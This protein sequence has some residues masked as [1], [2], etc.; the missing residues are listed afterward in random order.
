M[1]KIFPIGFALS[2]LAGWLLGAPWLS[3]A[4]GA[5][6]IPLAE[7]LLRPRKNSAGGQS[8]G[9][10][11][12]WGRTMPRIVLALVVA[13]TLWFGFQA[14]TFSWHTTLWLALSCGYVGGG[15]GIV[16][17]HELDH[18]RAWLDG[19]L[20]RLH[21]LMVGFGHYAL[22]HNRG[23]HRGVA[24]HAD[25]ATARRHES[26]W[27]FLPRY[28]RGVLR[29][30][31]ALSRKM[32]GP[33]NEAL[34]LLAATLMLFAAAFIVAGAPGLVFFLMQAAIA[35]LLVGAVDY[36][37]HWGLVRQTL[38]GKTERL[39]ERHI[40]DAPSVVSEVM[41]FN[42]PR[43]AAH[44]LKPWLQCDALTRSDTAPQMPTGYAGMVILAWIPQLYKKI[45]TPRLP[46]D[47]LTINPP[48]MANP[49]ESKPV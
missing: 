45:M 5:V 44:H 30:S 11:L 17:A 20:C 7:W 47:T 4:I 13:Q 48:L 14:D 27:Q 31:I 6:L 40:W 19:A 42:L 43:H 10:R 33:F 39:T 36:L 15:T 34:A 25:P 49:V 2:P 37:E 22:E 1:H 28:Y 9:P 35:Q 24:T 21:L 29:D 3:V 26:L 41:L 12:Q 38:N 46:V 23:H 32:P 8:A 18:R 16:L